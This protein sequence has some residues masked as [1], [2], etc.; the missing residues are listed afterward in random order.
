MND[1]HTC[2]KRAVGLFMK[3][4]DTGAETSI[5]LATSPD[6]AEVSGRYFAN[7]REK[8]PAPHATDPAVARRLWQISEELVGFSYLTES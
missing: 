6:V 8:A 3:S 1:V 5:Y 4:P 7:S 2:T